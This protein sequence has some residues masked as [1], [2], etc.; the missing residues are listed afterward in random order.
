[1]DLS[2]VKCEDSYSLTLCALVYRLHGRYHELAPNMVPMDYTRNPDVKLPIQLIVNMPELKVL[3][4]IIIVICPL[5]NSSTASSV[6]LVG[7][8]N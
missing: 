2:I 5:H 7:V 8:L 1:M 4:L 3:L 6:V